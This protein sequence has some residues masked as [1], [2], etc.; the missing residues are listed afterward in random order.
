MAFAEQTGDP[1]RL[2]VAHRAQGYSAFFLGRYVE[3]EATLGRGIELCAADIPPLRFA[4]YGEHPGVLCRLYR[5]WALAPLGRAAEAA[6]MTADGIALAR[7]LRNPHGV[8]W[9]L[10]CGSLVHALLRATETTRALAEEALELAATYRLP[11]WRAWSTFFAGWARTRSGEPAAGLALMAEGAEAWRA[12]GAALSTTLLQGLLAEAHAG[13]GDAQ[14]A[15]TH[16]DAAFAHHAAF[17]EAYMLAELHRIEAAVLELERRPAD[18]VRAALVKASEVAQAQGVAGFATRAACARAAFER[19][20]GRRDA[21]RAVLASA[22][23]GRKADC[24]D[25]AEARALMAELTE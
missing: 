8:A 3:A 19:R 10:C 25:L 20:Q 1:A 12:T 22:L 21:A 4:V 5:G 14:Q 13:Q 9:A 18:A 17:G 7:R 6:A 11:Q 23:A 16:L 2:A 24:P 15:R